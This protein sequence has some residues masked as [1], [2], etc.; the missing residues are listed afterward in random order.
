MKQNLNSVK[1][2]AKEEVFRRVALAKDH[3]EN[4]YY[5]PALTLAELSK[6]SCMNTF[7]FLRCFSQVYKKTPYQYLKEVRLQR[8]FELLKTKKY[9]VSKVVDLCGYQDVSSFN[10]TFKARYN[11]QPSRL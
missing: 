11:I 4:N 7:H 3:I 9:S 10:R 6:I 1:S 2:S 5:N 8:A